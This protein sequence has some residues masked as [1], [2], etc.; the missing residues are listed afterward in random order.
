[1]G[2]VTPQRERDTQTDSGVDWVP[3]PKESTLVQRTPPNSGTLK[4][5]KKFETDRVQGETHIPLPTSIAPNRHRMEGAYARVAPVPGSSVYGNIYTPAAMSVRRTRLASCFRAQ[6][7]DGDTEGDE[8][9]GSLHDFGTDYPGVDDAEPEF[10]LPDRDA[11]DI[12]GEREGE[13]DESDSD[14]SESSSSGESGFDY[15][16]E[17]T[18]VVEDAETVIE[19]GEGE[20]ATVVEP[21]VPDDIVIVSGHHTNRTHAGVSLEDGEGVVGDVVYSEDDSETEEESEAGTVEQVQTKPLPVPSQPVPE[22]STVTLL[23]DRHRP[24]K[25]QAVTDTTETEGTASLTQTA[26]GTATNTTAT[27]VPVASTRSL[28]ADTSIGTAVDTSVEGADTVSVAAVSDPLEQGLAADNLVVGAAGVGTAASP[29]SDTPAPSGPQAATPG[30]STPTVESTLQAEVDSLREQLRVALAGT[31]AAVEAERDAGQRRVDET[32]QATAKDQLDLFTERE[33]LVSANKALATERDMAS[34]ERDQAVSALTAVQA[35]WA[36]STSAYSAERGL[37]ETKVSELQSTIET[38][39]DETRQSLDELTARLTATE[40]AKDEA[41]AGLAESQTTIVTLTSDRD[42][43]LAS[44]EAS[45]AEVI[46]LT[47]RLTTATAEVTALQASLATSKTTLEESVAEVASVKAASGSELEMMGTKVAT[48]ETNHAAVKGNLEAKVA[49]LRDTLAA[50]K[51]ESESALSQSQAALLTAQTE[52]AETSAALA[53]SEAAVATLTAERDEVLSTSAAEAAEAADLK[54]LLAESSSMRADLDTALTASQTELVAAREALETAET[55]RVAALSE[56]QARIGTLTSARDAALAASAASAADLASLST[57][58]AE[59]DGTIDTLRQRL[60]GSQAEVVSGSQ[61]TV[62][63]Q[64]QLSTVSQERQRLQMTVA[65]LEARLQ[66]ALERGDGAEGRVDALLGELRVL[67]TTILAYQRDLEAAR[68]TLERAQ[69]ESATALTESQARV[70]TLTADRDGALAASA[71]EVSRLTDSLAESTAT[72]TS[73]KQRLEVAEALVTTR[74][75]ERETALQQTAE[76]QETLVSRERQLASVREEAGTLRSQVDSL[77]TANKTLEAT[78]KEEGERLERERDTAV[79]ETARVQQ[80]LASTQGQLASVRQELA[81]LHSKVDSLVTANKTLEISANE[82]RERVERVER[83]RD[84]V[85]GERAAFE[86]QVS[87]LKTKVSSL[88]AS[89]SDAGNNLTTLRQSLEGSQAE[90]EAARQEKA[91]LQAQVDTV[92]RERETLHESVTQLEERLQAAM[93]RGDG[94]ERERER[95][96]GDLAALTISL[97]ASQGQLVATRETLERAQEESATALAETQARVETL[98]ADKAGALDASDARVSELSV[99]LAEANTA[100]S[101]LSERLKAAG[102]QA[103]QSERERETAALE[104]AEVQRTLVSR[105]RELARASED[106]G[107]LRSEIDSLVTTNKALEVTVTEERERMEREKAGFESELSSVQ[108]EV[109]TLTACLTTASATLQTLQ[110]RLEE[111]N[112]EAVSAMDGMSSL[113]SQVVTVSR[114]SEALQAT[115][116]ELRGSLQTAMERREDVERERDELVAERDALAT[117][118]DDVVQ[119]RNSL[120]AAVVAL[121]ALPDTVSVGVQSIT[122]SRDADCQTA[123]VAV[124]PRHTQT[125]ISSAVS[126]ST[127]TVYVDTLAVTEMQTEIPP[128]LTVETQTECEAGGQSA[129]IIIETSVTGTG[130][131]TETVTGGVGVVDTDPQQPESDRETER[132]T[133]AVGGSG[134]DLEWQSILHSSGA[135]PEGQAAASAR[136]MAT[137]ASLPGFTLPTTLNMASLAAAAPQTSVPGHPMLLPSPPPISLAPTLGEGIQGEV[138]APL[139][140]LDPLPDILLRTEVDAET[141]NVMETA[142][143]ADGEQS[144]ADDREPS[145]PEVEDSRDSGSAEEYDESD[146]EGE[147]AV[148][149]DAHSQEERV[150]EREE[151]ELSDEAEGDTEET[152]DLMGPED[153]QLSPIEQI[154]E[155]EREAALSVNDLGLGWTVQYAY[156]RHITVDPELYHHSVE[157]EPIDSTQYTDALHQSIY[158]TDQQRRVAEAGKR[159]ANL[160]PLSVWQSELLEGYEDV[161]YGDGRSSLVTMGV[162]TVPYIGRY[163]SDVHC[164]NMGLNGYKAKQDGPFGVCWGIYFRTVTTVGGIVFRN[165]DEFDRQFEFGPKNAEGSYTGATYKKGFRRRLTKLGPDVKRIFSAPDGAAHVIGPSLVREVHQDLAGALRRVRLQPPR[166]LFGFTFVRQPFTYIL[167]E[168]L[169]VLLLRPTAAHPVAGFFTTDMWSPL[170]TVP[171]HPGVRD[172]TMDLPPLP[173]GVRVLEDL[174]TEEFAADYRDLPDVFTHIA[175]AMRQWLPGH[176]DVEREH[177]IIHAKQVCV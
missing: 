25:T 80:A 64:A 132:E 149:G 176:F 174:A 48:M 33:K 3:D 59:C 127:E 78:A 32:V 9:A 45:A 35:S 130:G 2:T 68:E 61:E 125:D 170:R 102:A 50:A 135:T 57:R 77:C 90:A 131:D 109:S 167:G 161:A 128:S 110:Q 44:S 31:E 150:E 37:L 49:E 81:A 143:Q 165:S 85:A 169:R 87:S 89:L 104:T 163:S 12:E 22:T 119:E 108:S 142:G 34:D 60:E 129:A 56:A 146:V 136:L 88:T 71:A 111:S 72:L 154:H 23:G 153:G 166:N 144:V 100:L 51:A 156:Q 42:Q 52:S 18:V 117:Q 29:V 157:T 121:E 14:S 152:E 16:Q 95:L 83:E 65:Q 168:N 84:T 17:K 30:F 171:G 55:D 137:V 67:S 11:S 4:L 126:Q 141:D 147:S 26:V 75:S 39:N 177:R 28:A 10:D 82:E 162:S 79:Q 41:L 13:R 96:V 36:S 21:E 5:I 53:T 115:V 69:E 91:S 58:V 47:A 15:D 122:A 40:D 116:T 175:D 172:D 113:Q 112:A 93:E 133:G 73:L 105:E 114:E 106:V 24:I 98:A 123:S 155:G 124:T 120:Q 54:S 103:S 159:P 173:E 20:R 43:A 140:L 118:R 134:L 160:P 7:Q 94:V 151:V 70:D 76:V 92:N 27:A 158:P 1:V 62:S 38:A 138:G 99:S 107:T 66:T 6:L 86:A 8:G 145:L 97:D 164:V 19:E 101:S 46:D 139:A 148:D 74:E 63:L